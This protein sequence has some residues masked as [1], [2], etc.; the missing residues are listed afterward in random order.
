[1][2]PEDIWIFVKT[3]LEQNGYYILAS[4]GLF[5]F[6]RGKYRAYAEEA[7]AKRTLAEANGKFCIMLEKC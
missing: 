4:I 2:H 6:L 3:F 7:Y 1:M 5:Y